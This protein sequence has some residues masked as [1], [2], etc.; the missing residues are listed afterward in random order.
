M[1]NKKY[2][3][4][5]GFFSFNPHLPYNSP[6][7]AELPVTKPNHQAQISLIRN[8]IYT[9]PVSISNLAVIPPYSPRFAPI[10]SHSATSLSRS[11]SHPSNIT[12]SS[13]IPRLLSLIRQTSLPRLLFL[14]YHS[15]SATPRLSFLASHHSPV[16]IR[17]LSDSPS[18]LRSPTR[19]DFIL[20]TSPR[21]NAPS[22]STRS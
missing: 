5:H 14:V 4:F 11:L 2:S 21:I 8:L 20:C 17:R 22:H 13:T 3:P 9:G 12:L 1:T 16:I 10:S 18:C 7:C 15:S 19:S 6:I